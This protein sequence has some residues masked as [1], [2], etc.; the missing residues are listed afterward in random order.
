MKADELRKFCAGLADRILAD[1]PEGTD[2]ELVVGANSDHSLFVIFGDDIAGPVHRMRRIGVVTAM[3]AVTKN[4]E[5][6]LGN[7]NASPFVLALADLIRPD[8]SE[9]EP[10]PIH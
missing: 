7:R 2:F 8:D 6:G 9:S 1:E 5:L 3:D 10:E 4:G